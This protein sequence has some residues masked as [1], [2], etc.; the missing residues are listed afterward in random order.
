VTLLGL[1]GDALEIACGTGVLQVLELQR[2]GRR[3]VAARDF[4]NALQS[5]DAAV[6]Q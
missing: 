1:R 4:M 5:G 2:A 3:A 6:F